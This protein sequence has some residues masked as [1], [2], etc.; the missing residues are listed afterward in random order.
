MTRILRFVVV[1]LVV[2]AGGVVHLETIGGGA[3]AAAQDP[4]P[5]SSLTGR[6]GAGR[7]GASTCPRRGKKKEKTK[8]SAAEKGAQSD[9]KSAED[10]DGGTEVEG[11]N[12]TM[13]P[14]GSSAGGD[15]SDASPEASVEDERA[16]VEAAKK[17]LALEGRKGSSITPG[18]ASRW[19]NRGAMTPIVAEV[20]ITVPLP[21]RAIPIAPGRE[22][23]GQ[24]LLGDEELLQARISLSAQHLETRGQDF[25]YRD[26][27]TSMGAVAEIEGADRDVDLFRWRAS[28]TYE[29]IAGSDFGAHLDLEYRARANGNRPTDRRINELYLSYGLTDFRRSGGPGFGVALGRVVIREAGLAEA[30]GGA[31]RLRMGP[32][33]HLGGFAGFTGNPFNYNWALARTEDF[34]TRWIRGGAFAAYRSPRVFANAATVLTYANIGSGR[35]GVDRVYLYLDAAYL[36]FDALH[37]FVTGRIDVVGGHPIQALEAVVAYDLATDLDLRFSVGR[38]ST[39]FYDVSTA[40][41]FVVDPVG[42]LA[43]ET[44]NPQA[45]IVDE[46]GA[47][48]VPYDAALA[49]VIYNSARARVGYRPLRSVEI[50]AFNDILL[51]DASSASRL[52][53]VAAQAVVPIASARVVPGVGARY[54]NVDLFDA[55]AQLSYIMDEQSQASSILQG[56][57]GRGHEGLYA[58]VD[59]RT[60][61]GDIPGTDGGI[62]VSYVLPG[63]WFPGRVLL[64][65]MIRYFRENVA[66]ERPSDPAVDQI[67]TPAGLVLIPLQESYLGFTSLEWRL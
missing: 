26:V 44:G 13:A 38:F 53:E 48:I 55:G 3:A 32:D 41:S 31:L 29:R 1:V 14:V 60:F 18:T 2:P 6:G 67:G 10:R 27:P 47:P 52:S 45:R 23:P 42:N 21:A 28:M 49:S 15:A 43:P 59:A 12:S 16:R 66:L 5:L 63:D 30:D 11:G 37:L 64:R 57:I 65:G 51:R 39:V 34:S 9:A 58:S 7:R 62:E 36:A 24:M 8:G 54:R 19:S 35:K 56:S 20:P 61:F 50:F 46:Q 33:L 22:T 4:G 40:Y 25:V 17:K